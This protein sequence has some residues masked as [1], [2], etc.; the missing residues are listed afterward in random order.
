MISE[1]TSP[2]PGRVE[3]PSVVGVLFGP[4]MP[5]GQPGPL[6]TWTNTMTK[7]VTS[8]VP[9]AVPPMVLAPTLARFAAN[10]V[11][12]EHRNVHRRSVRHLQASS[13]AGVGQDVRPPSQGTAGGR[14][15]APMRLDQLFAKLLA[16]PL[17]VRT[18]NPPDAADSVAAAAT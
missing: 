15:T 17:R 7:T 13:P 11:P 2:A 10:I 14:M 18:R 16:P 4:P 3:V 6:L 8:R 12:Q 5:R 9:P 1:M